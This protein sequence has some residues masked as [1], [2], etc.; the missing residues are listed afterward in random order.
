MLAMGIRLPLS[1]WRL[2]HGKE[3]TVGHNFK[4]ISL[5]TIKEVWCAGFSSDSD[6][7]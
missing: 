3:L 2:R 6:A 7:R 1:W 5:A 4:K